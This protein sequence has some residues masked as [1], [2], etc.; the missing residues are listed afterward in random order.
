MT[1]REARTLAH[2]LRV[3]AA[4]AAAR[5]ATP[6]G[7]DEATHETSTAAHHQ[8]LIR[9]ATQGTQVILNATPHTV[10]VYDP[11]GTRELMSL[12][13][14][15][16]VFGCADAYEFVDAMGTGEALVPISRIQGRTL[17]FGTLNPDRTAPER[18]GQRYPVPPEHPGVTWVVSL[19]TAAAA[20][21]RTDFLVPGQAVY[22][23]TR[24]QI[25]CAGLRDPLRPA[26]D[27]APPRPLP[28]QGAFHLC[29]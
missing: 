11:T 20:Q 22:G 29:H 3:C 24:R 15:G 21:D 6:A 25:G 8:A 16:Y 23:R 14:C 13:P 12:P 9:Q 1:E 28:D 7:T 4:L 10:N 26:C 5:Q 18:I 27:E 17:E 19:H 2:A